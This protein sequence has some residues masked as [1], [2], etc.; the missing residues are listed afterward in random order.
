MSSEAE[1]ETR[2]WKDLKGS[3]IVMLGLAGADDAHAQPMNAFFDG[4]RGPFWFFTTSD[5]GI[6]DRLAQ[7]HRGILHY[8]SKGHDLFACVH[9]QLVIDN[10]AATI[11]RFWGPSVAAWF[12]KG[13]DDPKLTLLRMD[14][15]HAHIW[16]V[17]SRIG[18]A[19]QR[20]FGSGD[21]IKRD[22]EKN[23]AEVR[24]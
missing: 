21:P 8:A 2:F 4:E 1:I 18:A 13:R 10:D 9:G 24:L 23:V 20:V 15:D 22:Y 3:S 12:E 16:Q 5:N 11:D 14:V 6:V 17:G 7:S 19:V